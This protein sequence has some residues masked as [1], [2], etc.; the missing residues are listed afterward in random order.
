M[1]QLCG[2]KRLAPE[3]RDEV[4]VLG[5]V[6][7]QQL[8]GGGTLQNA[9]EGDVDGRHPTRAETA[10]EPVSIG[11]LRLEQR[12]AQSP[13]ALMGSVARPAGRA[14][15]CPRTGSRLGAIALVIAVL[16]TL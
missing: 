14:R 1:D 13:L 5:Q 11:D 10:V 3:A 9:V 4:L 2:G 8:H 6:L 15:A 12:H 7:G 16:L